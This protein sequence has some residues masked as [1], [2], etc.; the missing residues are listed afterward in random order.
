MAK[1]IQDLR[2]E[3]GYRSAKDFAAAMGIALSTYNRYENQ[4]EA[5]PLKQAWAIADFLGCSIDM[6]VGREPVSAEGMRGDVQKFYDELSEDGRELMDD[7]MELVALREEKADRRRAREERRQ[8]ERVCSY[9]EMLF[10]Q[11]L[12]GDPELAHVTLFGE[13]ED[14]RR[15]FESFV[16]DKTASGKKGDAE[17]VLR[18]TMDAYDRIHSVGRRWPLAGGPALSMEYTGR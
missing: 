10:V 7:M 9:Y 17:E 2:R 18:K 15:G 4:P 12:D 16:K 8:Y 14:M 1:N 3:A 5:I 11:K 6:V 13:P